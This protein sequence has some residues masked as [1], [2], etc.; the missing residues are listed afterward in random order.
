MVGP[1]CAM[2]QR[3]FPTPRIA[4]AELMTP[5]DPPSADG[6]CLARAVHEVRNSSGSLLPRPSARAEPLLAAAASLLY[7]IRGIG[8][9]G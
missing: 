7:C 5:Y 4:G 8:D 3:R 2:C 6:E 9:R 1:A